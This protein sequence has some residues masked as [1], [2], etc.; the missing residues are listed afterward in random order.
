M[1]E[2]QLVAALNEATQTVEQQRQLLDTQTHEP[3]LMKRWVFGSRRELFGADDPRQKSLFEVGEPPADLEAAESGKVGEPQQE[4]A[5]VR[6]AMVPE[7]RRIQL[8][9]GI[10]AAPE[11]IGYSRRR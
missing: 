5:R 7:F 4:L 10:I 2:A 11:L 1:R 8:P 9:P 6:G 3:A